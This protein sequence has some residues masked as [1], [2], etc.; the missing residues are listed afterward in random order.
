M[1]GNKQERLRSRGSDV[2][3]W[4]VFFSMMAVL[5]F[6]TAILIAERAYYVHLVVTSK[7]EKTSWSQNKPFFADFAGHIFVL[8]R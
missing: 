2:K 8:Q 4:I 5:F 1:N 6:V 7:I 3:G